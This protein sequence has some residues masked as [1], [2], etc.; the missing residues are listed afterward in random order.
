MSDI[1]PPWPFPT[2]QAHPKPAEASAQC[3]P[4]TVQV[5]QVRE[6][7][8]DHAVEE[9]FPASDPVAVVSTKVVETASND[10]AADPAAGR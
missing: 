1:K 4:P 5:Q 3:A 6:S 9:S 10:S 2:A 8:L 7:T